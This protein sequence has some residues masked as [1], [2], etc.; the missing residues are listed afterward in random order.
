MSIEGYLF[1]Q[2]FPQKKRAGE[3]MGLGGKDGENALPQERLGHLA[4][5][6]GVS[7]LQNKLQIALTRHGSIKLCY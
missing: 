1:S 4:R 7:F 3:R 5:A 2:H 6:E